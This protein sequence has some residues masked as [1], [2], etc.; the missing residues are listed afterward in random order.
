MHKADV[1]ESWEK[2]QISYE[3]NRLTKILRYP[4]LNPIEREIAQMQ[5]DDY[6]TLLSNGGTN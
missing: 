2:E 3:I 4:E 5:L 1:A 6:Y